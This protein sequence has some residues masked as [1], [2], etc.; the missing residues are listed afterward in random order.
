M[1]TPNVARIPTFVVITAPEDA[2]NAAGV[3]LVKTRDVVHAMSSGSR[4]GLHQ[5]PH[6]PIHAHESKRRIALA[7]NCDSSLLAVC[8]GSSVQAYSVKAALDGKTD[9]ALFSW[10][11][12]DNSQITQVSCSL[13]L[14]ATNTPDVCTDRLAV[15]FNAWHLRKA[16]GLRCQ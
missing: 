15:P 1:R 9:E 8:C 10:H 2:G 3:H 16:F 6:V 11:T 5:L 14:H 12:S 13:C 4:P 7:L